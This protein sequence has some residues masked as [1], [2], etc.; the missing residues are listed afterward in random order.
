M[1]RHTVHKGIDDLNST[2]NQLNLVDTKT[3]HHTTTKEYQ[4]SISQE[5][6]PKI[7]HILGY[8]V[9][10]NTLKIVEIIHHMFLGNI[11]I[12]LEI[13]NR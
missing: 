11:G 6:F 5:T 12:K 2:I 4:H 7:D 13:L 8:K 3:I 9:N 10:H 1:N